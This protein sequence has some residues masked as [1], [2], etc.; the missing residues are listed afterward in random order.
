MNATN[1]TVFEQLCEE[2][3]WLCQKFAQKIV[4]VSEENDMNISEA[5]SLYRGFGK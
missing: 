4:D 5:S 2:W 1:E 3:A